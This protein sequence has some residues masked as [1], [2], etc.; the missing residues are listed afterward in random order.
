MAIDP[1][2]E[3]R[4]YRCE[5]CRQPLG[6]ILRDCNRIRRLW[7]FW[8][9]LD[10]E[11]LP[12][13]Q[14]ILA[15]PRSLFRIHGMNSGSVECGTCGAIQEWIPAKDAMQDLIGRYEERYGLKVNGELAYNPD[16]QE[17]VRSG[18]DD[19]GVNAR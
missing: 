16:R 13:C 4:I 7:V 17:S 8:N 3:P 10:D 9:V 6:V 19:V 2:Y 11:H 15:L 12:D 1:T 18:A 14:Q 5:H